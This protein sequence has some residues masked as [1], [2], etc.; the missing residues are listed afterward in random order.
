MNVVGSPLT[1]ATPPTVMGL[2]TWSWMLLGNVLDGACCV[3]NQVMPEYLG[4]IPLCGTMMIGGGALILYAIG[5]IVD[6]QPA[7]TLLGNVAGVIPNGMKWFRLPS[8]FTEYPGLIAVLAWSDYI[9]IPLSALSS[10]VSALI[11]A[12]VIQ[13]S[14][15]ALLMH[16]TAV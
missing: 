4:A 5:S 3:V 6:D 2:V 8:V 15:P 1:A 12:G 11:G 9:C 14:E 13:D 16:T 7:W 10:L